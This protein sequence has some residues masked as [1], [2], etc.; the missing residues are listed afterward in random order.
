ME[1]VKENGA[2][3][4]SSRNAQPGE[5]IGLVGWLSLYV[6]GALTFFFILTHILAIHFV[7]GEVTTAAKVYRDLNSPF[8]S[9]ISLGL[10]FL[11]IFHG[12][13]GL[14]RVLLDLEIFGKRGDRSLVAALVVIGLGLA[15][16]GIKIFSQFKALIQ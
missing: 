6:S 3:I 14:R 9:F 1:N 10:L 7:S 15:L 11:G 5:R 2:M 13:I 4:S 12:L 16:F 8:L